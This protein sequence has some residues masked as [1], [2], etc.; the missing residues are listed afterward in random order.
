MNEVTATGIT[1]KS[2]FADW[3]AE[4]LAQVYT[5]HLPFNENEFAFSYRL[6]IMN[7]GLPSWLKHWIA[8]R[9]KSQQ[10]EPLTNKKTAMRTTN[11]RFSIT[12]E[13]RGDINTLLHLAPY[14]I[15]DELRVLCSTFK[16]DLVYSF[17]S[18][19]PIMK[20]ALHL[21]KLCGVMLV[22]HFV[23][24]WPGTN[25][26]RSLLKLLFVPWQTRLLRKALK[27]SPIRLSICDAM[28][29][30][31]E[32]RY[33]PPFY[34]FMH[35]VEPDN[36]VACDAYKGKNKKIRLVYIGGLHLNRWRPLLEIAEELSIIIDSEEIDAEIMIYAPKND[37]QKYQAL[38]G[39]SPVITFGGTIPKGVTATACKE[40]DIL[41]HVE[42]FD[43]NN[44]DYTLYS[45]STKIPEYMMSGRP[46]FA[47]GP[48]DVA[49]I[50]YI[51]ETSCGIVV[52]E[53]QREL[54]N[55]RLRQILASKELRMILGNQ[56][57]KVALEKHCAQ[58][59][60]KR[61]RELLTQV[62]NYNKANS[63]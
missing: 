45:I 14:N 27:I 22:P 28:S 40:A 11:N 50:R 60:R 48:Q 33:D 55:R 36:Y 32:R 39:R 56:G 20:W 21:A 24:D 61:F 54:L 38:L 53:R 30:E 43:R 23:D 2:L 25:Y 37:L 3:P 7:L 15:P 47:Y 6:S 19:I 9:Q 5:E 58:T 49:S 63:L 62:A 51:S 8:G 57:R 10:N 29:L 35:C 12:P 13:M 16:P 46:I 1:V 18:N 59:Q 44:Q 34:A 31:Y 52:G 17:L 26:R 41:I 4:N 42:S